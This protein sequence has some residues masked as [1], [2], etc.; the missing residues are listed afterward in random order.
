MSLC[1]NI[2]S[3]VECS[4]SPLQIGREYGEQAENEIQRNVELFSSKWN[5]NKCGETTTRIKHVIKKY[6]PEI[7]SEL[8][9]IAEGAKVNINHLLLMNHVDTFEDNVERCTPLI[10]RNSPNGTIV[11]KN[12]DAPVNED[13]S[14]IIRKCIPQEGIPFIQ[15]TYAGW[16]SGFD[17]MNAE[18]LANTHGSVGSV[19]DKSGQRIDIRLKSYQLMSVCRTT[20]DFITGF[21]ETPLTGK[22]FNIAVG[23]ASGNTAMLDAALPFIAV[24]NR[25]KKFDYATNIYKFPGLETADMR[26]AG[27]RDICGYRYGYL[28]WREETNPPKKLDD[29]KT[30]LSSHEP[31]APCRHGGIHGAKTLWSMIN[32]TKAKKVLLAYGNPCKN[33]YREYSL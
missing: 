8:T 20:D 1:E 25:N 7:Y 29:I 9:G 16:L 30:L 24:Y 32:L 22:G 19:F 10:L 14:F 23:D 17:C 33:E 26:P 12:N 21:N 3:F 11:A 2:F 27:K 6:L 18:G 15:V 28:K 5:I 31:W 13:Y 4:G